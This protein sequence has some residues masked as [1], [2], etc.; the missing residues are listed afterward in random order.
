MQAIITG[1]IPKNLSDAL[2]LGYKE[3]EIK[4]MRGYVSRRGFNQLEA[5]IHIGA[6]RRAGQLY[7]MSPAYDSSRYCLRHYLS[8]DSK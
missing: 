8:R 7:Y 1:T 5:P 6:G 3:T 2:S 4:R